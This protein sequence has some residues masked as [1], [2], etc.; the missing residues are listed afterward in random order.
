MTAFTHSKYNLVVVL[1]DLKNCK[2]YPGNF[3]YVQNFSSNPIYFFLPVDIIAEITLP[4]G[5]KLVPCKR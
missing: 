1:V 5:F 4:P 2:S 3:I